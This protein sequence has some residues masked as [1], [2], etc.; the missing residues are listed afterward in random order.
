MGFPALL[1]L[2]LFLELGH[3][4]EPKAM[5]ADSEPQ[6][7]SCLNIPFN[8]PDQ[9]LQVGVATSGLVRW[10]LDIWTPVLIPEQLVVLSTE[11]SPHFHSELWQNHIHSASQSCPYKCL[12]LLLPPLL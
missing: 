10:V 6:R 8:L 3:F 2:L 4:S 7:S 12:P 5:L 11:P 1:G 9:D